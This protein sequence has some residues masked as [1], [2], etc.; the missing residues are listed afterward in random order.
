MKKTIVLLLSLLMLLSLTA[1]G[2]GEAEDT[3]V[4]TR[5]N[6][7]DLQSVSPEDAEAASQAPFAFCYQELELIPGARFEADKLP[8]AA[9]TYEV[10]SCAIEGTD[11]VYNYETFEV[12]AYDDGNGAVIYSI[13]FIDP[14]LTTPEGLALGDSTQTVLELYG[15]DYVEEGT[16]WT[17]T[18]GNTQLQL[19]LQNGAVSSIEYRMCG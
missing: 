2:S 5:S 4:I 9:S 18:R 12:T 15:E 13:Y 19:I 6:G 17:Y 8:Q 11:Q 1:C 14:N 16:A 3:P 7:D 10:P